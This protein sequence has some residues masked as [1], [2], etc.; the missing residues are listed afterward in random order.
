MTG[1]L[2]V[3]AATLGGVLGAALHVMVLFGA[4]VVKRI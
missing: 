4:R 1:L 3:F 2:A